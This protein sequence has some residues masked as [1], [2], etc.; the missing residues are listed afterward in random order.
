M[1]SPTRFKTVKDKEKCNLVRKTEELA[2][3]TKR[4]EQKEKQT[5]N[6]INSVTLILQMGML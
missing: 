5:K 1:H 2:L 3:Q 6:S 4:I